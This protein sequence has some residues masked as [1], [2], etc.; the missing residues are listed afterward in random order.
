VSTEDCSEAST[1]RHEPIVCDHDPGELALRRAGWRAVREQVE[2]VERSR[3]RGGFRITFQGPREAVEAVED[4]IA[5]ERQCCA[6][7]D[8]QLSVTADAAVLEV[9]AP[10]DQLEPLARAFG[11]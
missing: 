1:R 6:W 10:G 2:I 5:A 8:W 4:L 11:A 7:A 9:T 3:F